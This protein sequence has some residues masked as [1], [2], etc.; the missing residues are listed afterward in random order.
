MVKLVIHENMFSDLHSQN[1]NFFCCV[2]TSNAGSLLTTG[3][4]R[5]VMFLVTP[6]GGYWLFTG[7]GCCCI[8]CCKTPRTRLIGII[9]SL[10]GRRGPPTNAMGGWPESIYSA[11]LEASGN[12]LINLPRMSAPWRRTLAGSIASVV[13]IRSTANR[14]EAQIGAG[15]PMAAEN[16][17]KMMLFQRV[18]IMGQL[19]LVG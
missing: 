12:E 6:L 11:A 1:K 4:D 15:S 14:S 13:I 18:R 2:S 3:R 19:L 5:V 10:V 8:S 7:C 16:A 9:A 17:W